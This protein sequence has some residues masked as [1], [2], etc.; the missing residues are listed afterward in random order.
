MPPDRA[1]TINSQGRQKS[2][3]ECAKGK[4]KC[5]L[6]YPKCARCTRQKQPCTYPPQPAESL[7]SILQ[8]DTIYTQDGFTDLMH[9]EDAA[10]PLGIDVPSLPSASNVELLDFDFLVGSTTLDATSNV[11]DNS[12]RCDNQLVLERPHDIVDTAFTAPQMASFAKSHV[13]WSVERLKLAP[14]MMVE[15]KGTP[16][17]HPMLYDEYMPKSL[18]DAYT[19]SALYIARN[20]TN[21]D[22]VAK[23]IT[24][25]VD[26]LLTSPFPQQPNELLARAHALIVY[27]T[28]LAFSGEAGYCKQAELLLPQMED[29]GNALLPCA[30]RQLDPTGPLPLYPSAAACGAWTSYIFRESLRRTVLSLFHLIITCKMLQGQL[31]SCRTRLAMGNRFTLSA[32]LWSAKNPLEF[33]IAWNNKNHFL[34]RELDFT[35]VMRDAEPDDIDV[36][37]RMM[38][39]G[40]Q[41]VDVS[42]H[43]L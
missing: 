41:G 36:F 31:K 39:V 4:R 16:W 13:A 2:C 6:S 32:H 43:I 34:V 10:I 28:M 27:Q 20:G 1:R 5:S 7:E 9:M 24:E 22:L 37:S 33:A 19:A 8:D 40:L 30:A 3:A 12:P 42:F 29:I 23:I 21:D 38:M 15:Q 26:E 35:E 25:R 11:L 14:K 17:Q 18:Q